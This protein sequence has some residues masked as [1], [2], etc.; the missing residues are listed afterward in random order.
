[1]LALPDYAFNAFTN[2]QLLPSSSTTSF[3]A[4]LAIYRDASTGVHIR[5]AC[6]DEFPE[7]RATSSSVGSTH[8]LLYAHLRRGDTWL[9]KV[10]HNFNRNS[11]RDAFHSRTRLTIEAL[12]RL[13]DARGLNSKWVFLSDNRTAADEGV[14]WVKH[15]SSGQRHAA[16]TLDSACSVC[17]MLSMRGADGILQSTMRGYSSFSTVPALMGGLPLYSVADGL[18][19]M[20]RSEALLAFHRGE[21]AAF[22]DAAQAHRDRTRS[23]AHG[24]RPFRARA[25]GRRGVLP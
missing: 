1:M 21:E 6:D 12:V 10:R 17:T 13:L 16:V 22:L 3:E 8:L 18:S 11:S 7:V 2:A 15:A 19:G 25:R 14:A 5:P 23:E 9:S 20:L 24:R 4:F